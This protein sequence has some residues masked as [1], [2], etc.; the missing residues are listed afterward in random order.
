MDHCDLARPVKFEHAEIAIEDERHPLGRDVVG[1]VD[2]RRWVEEYWYRTGMRNGPACR[3]LTGS[4]G[5]DRGVDVVNKQVI[6]VGVGRSGIAAAHLLHAQGARVILTDQKT[7]AD[8]G[9]GFSHLTNK[10]IDV[11]VGT[12]YPD[13]LERAECLVISP[14]VRSNLEA[15]V[16]ARKR[17]AIVMGEL[18]L[19]SRYVTVPIIAVTGTNG[20]S[21]TVTLLGQM[22]ERTG[23][24]PFVGGNLGVPLSEAALSMIT[25]RGQGGVAHASC[26]IAVVEVS[27][28]QLETIDSFH[29]WVSA[30]LNISP[31]HLDRY[32]SFDDYVA[33]K[34]RIFA[35]QTPQD[36]AVFNL[37][38]ELVKG[39]MSRSAAS[40]MGFTRRSDLGPEVE[41]GAWWKG[42]AFMIKRQGREEVVCTTQQIRLQGIH[43]HENAMAAATIGMVA[44]CSVA[45]IRDTLKTFP[46]LEHAMEFVRDRRGVRFINDSKGTNIDATLKAIESFD[47]P[48]ILIAGGRHKGGDFAKLQGPI[49]NRVKHLIVIGESTP[50]I[51]EA[52][53][54]WDRVSQADSLR[55]A[56]DLA[57]EHAVSGDVVLF[58]PACSSFDMFVD[59][60][61]RGQQ[62]K[63]LVKE[64]GR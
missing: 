3:R 41:G 64:L 56:V 47:R 36:F 25:E 50:Q 38:D 2:M 20:K 33:A 23:K 62:F 42:D 9:E 22:L 45:S 37:D 21:T 49:R 34:A 35:N 57:R 19:A 55:A 8:V 48:L 17:G 7:E 24:R 26:D 52:I 51:L 18:E 15:F 13:I 60:Q 39:M 32:D 16:R 54:P 27:S 40:P 53:V 5:K 30:M 28:F 63:K 61:D 43:N 46:G 10:G 59:Y 29:P 4:C 12:D 44:G 1:N 6:V 11:R 31:D 14:G 58:S